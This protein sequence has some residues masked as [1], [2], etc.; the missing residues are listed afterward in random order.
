MDHPFIGPLPV[1]TFF[2]DFL[3]VNDV[4]PLSASPLF[5]EM[6]NATCEE[7]MRDSF[8]RPPVPVVFLSFSYDRL[9]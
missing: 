1:E 8:V 6:A 4:A 3:P 5:V 2:E 7:R 9:S